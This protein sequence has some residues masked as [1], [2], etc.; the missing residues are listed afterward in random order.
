MK[1]LRGVLFDAVGT[2][3]EL[4]EPV[5]DTYARVAREHGVAIA[6]WRLDDAFGR[7]LRRRPAM[8]FPDLPQDEV[9]EAERAWWREVVRGTFLA[10]DSTLRFERFDALFA[11]LFDHYAGSAAW[12]L[13]PG[14]L[15]A[16]S[17]LRGRGCLL[18]VISNFDHRLPEVLHSLEIAG[19]FGS[20]TLPGTCRAAKPARRIFETALASLTLARD[21]ACYV[22]DD[23]TVD[24]EGARGAGLAAF[25]VTSLASLAELPAHLEAAATL[26]R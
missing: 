25:D 22:G 1:R 20:V 5:G 9:A 14:S 26:G 19:L 4:R 18:G 8:L 11:E 15:E 10:A 3:I 23:A 17:A 7:I 12:R 16:L 21:E 13:R 6:P 24:L 2:L